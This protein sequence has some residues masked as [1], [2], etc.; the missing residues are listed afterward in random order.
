MIY[1][2]HFNKWSVKVSGG[3]VIEVNNDSWTWRANSQENTFE[4]VYGTRKNKVQP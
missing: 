1:N 4:E 2:I 3:K